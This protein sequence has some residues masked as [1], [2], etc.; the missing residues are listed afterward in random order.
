[1]ALERER[2]VNGDAI[3]GFERGL[4]LRD[5]T[6]AI[7]VFFSDDQRYLNVPPN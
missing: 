6:G 3:Q 4:I 1:M 7:F 5:S 2:G